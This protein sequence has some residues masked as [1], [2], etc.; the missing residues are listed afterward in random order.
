[1]KFAARPARL[2]KCSAWGTTPQAA[3]RPAPLQGSH[4]KHKRRNIGSPGGE[5]SP[6]VTEGWFHAQSLIIKA[7]AAAARGLAALLRNYRQV[8]NL[9]HARPGRRGRRPLLRGKVHRAFFVSAPAKF[10]RGRVAPPYRVAYYFLHTKR[11]ACIFQQAAQI[12]NLCNY[13]MPA[14]A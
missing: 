2:F 6:Q 3:S 13:I 1:M 8:C 5:L 12:L 10:R 4:Y 14:A 11:A 7:R 9:F